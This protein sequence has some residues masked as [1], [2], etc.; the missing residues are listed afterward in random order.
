LGAGAFGGE[1]R[2]RVLH[3]HHPNPK[4]SAKMPHKNQICG[5]LEPPCLNSKFLKKVQ[6][7]KMFI[8][9]DRRRV[10]EI[11][12]DPEDKRDVLKLSKRVAEFQGSIKLITKEIN[13]SALVNLRVLNLYDNELT[14]L[15]GIGMLAQT[16]LEEINLGSNKLTELPTEVI[17]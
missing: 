6:I 3:R 16:P 5:I 8:K 4:S 2:Y 11:L 7:K 15:A 12:K 10:D 1:Q 9:K 13:I 14:S 17:M